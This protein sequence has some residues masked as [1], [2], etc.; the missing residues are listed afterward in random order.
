[1][2]DVITFFKE[3]HKNRLISEGNVD[4]DEN[5]DLEPAHEDQVEDEDT[6]PE[7][8]QHVKAVKEVNYFLEKGILIGCYLHEETL[9]KSTEYI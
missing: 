9:Y 4:E 5:E 2:E 7:P 1:M 3:Y 6:P 8:P